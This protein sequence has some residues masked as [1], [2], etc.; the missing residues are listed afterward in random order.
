[1][2]S[3]SIVVPFQKGPCGEGGRMRGFLL[4]LLL[5]PGVV[6]LVLLLI[7]FLNSGV[8]HHKRRWSDIYEGDVGS[9]WERRQIKLHT[10]CDVPATLNKLKTTFVDGARS[11]FAPTLVSC[12]D[13][14]HFLK[15]LPGR[16]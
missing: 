12:P 16:S 3:G 5:L 10:S 14:K 2:I 4:P 8:V 1:M 6:V 9:A 7:F 11:I 15:M 13:Q